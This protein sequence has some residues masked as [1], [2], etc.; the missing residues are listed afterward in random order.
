M[1]KLILLF[2]AI[3]FYSINVFSSDSISVV[4]GNTSTYKIL[5]QNNAPESVSE[6]A[7]DLKRLIKKSTGAELSI[8][9]SSSEG[10]YIVIGDACKQY[11]VDGSLL[12]HDAFILKQEG[13]NIFLTGRDEVPGMEG[14]N[15]IGTWDYYKFYNIQR[16]RR[17]L[18]AGSYNA[19]I[20]FVKDYMGVR[21]YMPT[22]NGEEVPQLGE[23]KI[24][25]GLNRTVEP[26]FRQRR[27]DFTDWAKGKMDQVL[28]G[29]EDEYDK[30]ENIDA[31]V[32]WGRHLRHTNPKVMPNGHSWRQWIPADKISASSIAAAAGIPNEGYGLT[33]P[34]FFA[35]V[36]G[37][38]QTKYKSAAQNGGQLD[39][40]DEKM[41][42]TYA[43]NIKKYYQKNKNVKM[44]GLSQNDGGE[45]CEC[46]F[47][48]AWDPIPQDMNKQSDELFLTDRFL[49][50]QKNV[51]VQVMEEFPD[52][53]FGIIAYHE[54]G[55]APIRETIPENFYVESFYNYFPNL[56]YL[57]EKRKDFEDAIVDWGKLTD[58]F[59]FGSFYFAYGNH[60]FPWST[61]DA[62]T[63]MIDHIVK[64]NVQNFQIIFGSEY[65]MIG[66]LGP[67]QWLV[68]QLLW[69]PS[70]SVDS[71][72]NDWY[73]GAFTPEIGILVRE[74]FETIEDRFAEESAKYPDFWDDRSRKQLQID[75]AVFTSIKSQCAALIQ[76]IKKLAAEKPERI[77]WRVQQITKTWEFTELTVD[78]NEAAKAYRINPTSGNFDLAFNLGQQRL[79]MIYDPANCYS[80][81]P[82]CVEVS[83]TKATLGIVTEN[84]TFEKKSLNVPKYAYGIDVSQSNLTE[85]TEKGASFGK[86]ENEF[87]NNQTTQPVMADGVTNGSIL[88]TDEGIYV[89]M[90][91]KEPYKEEIVISEDSAKPWQGD[92]FEVF[93][94]PSGGTD[95][96]FQFIVNPAN[97]GVAFA[98]KGDTGMDETYSPNWKHG[99]TIYGGGW[100]MRMFVPWKDL[101]GIPQSGEKWSA[102]FYRSR[103]AHT[104]ELSAWSPTGD[105]FRMPEMFGEIIFTGG[106]LSSKTL[107]E[108]FEIKVYPNPTNNKIHFSGNTDFMNSLEQTVVYDAQGSK[109]IIVEADVTTFDVSHFSPGLYFIRFKLKNGV[110]EI[111][112]FIVKR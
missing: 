6:A 112:S 53:E 73:N 30:K 108:N 62:Q 109:L 64:N 63:W 61:V 34:E 35:L 2:F 110:N 41:T 101:G 7:S 71:L 16:W 78:A 44:Y 29:G 102:N 77:Q 33:E 8:V 100:S 4:N 107:K 79:K 97:A 27:M 37:V 47:C 3:I 49:K 75:L 12:S 104:K 66:Q 43:D 24:P 81:S 99:A 36:N 39:V 50:F 86:G 96:Y 94:T 74:Y 68:S 87:K 69:D 20:Q 13:D 51:A 21:W 45:H 98:N 19:V 85:W 52:T 93:F 48:K 67:D 25:V 32:K 54:T 76:Q 106:P 95:E 46:E 58:K 80:V 56:Y 28:N 65:P 72:L 57:P 89:M 92:D 26:Y 59:T 91:G 38:R 90:W 103:W 23:I 9:N 55:G 15:E 88:Y 83:E 70:Q 18:S 1:N 105:H 42:K 10:K 22:E 31:S 17:T 5:I 40:S 60:S 84:K 11:G 14:E 82:I 111:H